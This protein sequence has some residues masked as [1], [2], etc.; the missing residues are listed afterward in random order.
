VTVSLVLFPVLQLDTAKG[1][2]I[3]LI[4]ETWIKDDKV[5][6]SLMGVS[7]SKSGSPLSGMLYMWNNGWRKYCL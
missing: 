4:I 2:E 3:A 5:L 6:E 1:N 7:C